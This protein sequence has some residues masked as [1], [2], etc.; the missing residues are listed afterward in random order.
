M[1]DNEQP[2]RADHAYIARHHLNGKTVVHIAGL[3]ALG[4]IGAAHYVTEHLPEL[5]SEFGDSSLSMAVTTEFDGMAPTS[6]SVLIPPRAW[7]E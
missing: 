5:W 6:M 3:H 1:D 4:S 7:T 2:R